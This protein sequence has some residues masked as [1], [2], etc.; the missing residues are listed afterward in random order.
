MAKKYFIR[1]NRNG[2]LFNIPIRQWILDHQELFPQYGFTNS[3]SDFP[4]TYQIRNLLTR[5]FGYI[6]IEENNLI[7]LTA[8]AP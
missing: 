1:E 4:T 7:V 3:Q 8:F 6:V 2:H 5:E